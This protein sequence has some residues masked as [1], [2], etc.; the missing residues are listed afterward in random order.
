[1]NKKHTLYRIWDNGSLIY[2]GRT[3]QK[4]SS[5]LRGHFFAKPMHLKIG[6]NLVDYVDYAEFAS[7]ADMYVAE[8]YFIN[9][10]K[11][12]LN[13][14]DKAKDD[15]TYDCWHLDLIKWK[16]WEEM[17]LRLAGWKSEIER[18]NKTGDYPK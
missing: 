13:V 7:V 8:V 11:P 12:V 2:V 17:D 9:K 5:R 6:I 1:M 10:L 18:R 3:N 15:M 14:D 4:L 16:E